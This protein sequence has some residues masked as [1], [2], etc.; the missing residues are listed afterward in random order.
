MDQL[1]QVLQSLAIGLQQLSG[2]VSQLEGV[3]SEQNNLI[4]VL[5]SALISNGN[6]DRESLLNAVR[7][8]VKITKGISEEILDDEDNT[9][10]KKKEIEDEFEK[11]LEEL[12]TMI[13][14]KVDLLE[15]NTEKMVEEIL[16]A[17]KKYKE[18]QEKIKEMQNKPDIAVADATL[19]NQLDQQQKKKGKIITN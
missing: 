3:I 16:E 9:E 10:E 18:M 14:D 2:K 6:L 7:D 12:I 1:N 13:N 8:Y 4:N 5:L 11:Q 19:L 15:G 17:K